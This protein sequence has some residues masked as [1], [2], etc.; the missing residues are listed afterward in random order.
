MTLKLKGGKIAAVGASKGEE[1]LWE[2][3]REGS[4]VVDCEG[5]FLCPGLVRYSLIFIFSRIYTDQFTRPSRST[6]MSILF[7]SQRRE[8]RESMSS[9]LFRS[10]TLPRS[11]RL[12]TSPSSRTATPGTAVSN[13]L[14]LTSI[15]SLTPSPSLRRIM[16]RP[17]NSSRR[18][19]SIFELLTSSKV[20]H[21]PLLTLL[22]PSRSAYV[23]PH[24]P[25]F[26]SR[27][28]TTVRDVGGATKGIANA[29]E[30]FLISGPRIF[31]GG[32]VMSQT[33]SLYPHQTSTTIYLLTST[34]RLVV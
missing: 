32:A 24:R 7:V 18:I 4:I 12:L 22:S 28:F 6:A 34:S 23:L 5:I 17:S 10:L 1:D 31:Q 15:S 30:E 2:A 20:S 16:S 29:T 19:P 9:T 8:E 33:V 11:S 25:G 13:N 3:E 21:S 26:L 14:N 27:G